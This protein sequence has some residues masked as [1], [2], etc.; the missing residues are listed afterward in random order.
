MIKE[1]QIQNFRSIHKETLGLGKITVLTGA[2]NSGKSSILYGLMVLQDFVTNPNQSLDS[3]FALSFINL[4]GFTEVKT[5]GS[6]PEQ[7]IQLGITASQDHLERNQANYNL[8]LRESETSIHLSSRSGKFSF[9]ASLDIGLPYV[10]NKEKKFSATANNQT[11]DFKWNGIESYALETSELVPDLKMALNSPLAALTNTDFVPI[12]RGFTKP[13]Y[14]LVPMTGII[15]TEEEI[16]TMLKTEQQE[17]IDILNKY[18]E[19]ISGRIIQLPQNG[20]PGLFSLLAKNPKTG[21]TNFL[22]NE[23]SGV[24]HIVTILAK[25]FQKGKSFIC[26][27][28]PEIHLHPSMI[29]DVTNAFVK[30]VTESDNRQF[31]VSTHSEHFVSALLQKVTEGEINSDDVRIYHLSQTE[32]GAHIDRQKVNYAGQ[33]EGGLSHFYE[34]ELAGLKSLFKLKN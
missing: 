34:T 33:V 13:Y 6:A 17:Q 24:N 12:L 28:E 9:N 10:P 2:N 19:K 30:I 29:R 21:Q 31:L 7:S 3:L 18:L 1:V 20:T 15:N 14:N 25:I 26:I 23:G 8:I 5:R 11:I 22:V 16:A 4:G 32:K 27:D